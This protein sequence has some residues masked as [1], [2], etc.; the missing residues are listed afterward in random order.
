MVPSS[1]GDEESKLEVVKRTV[2]RVPAVCFNEQKFLDKEDYQVLVQPQS[3]AVRGQEALAR[4][5]FVLERAL[6]LRGMGATIISDYKFKENYLKRA[7]Q[8]VLSVLN[9]PEDE[10][11]HNILMIGPQIGIVCI[12]V[13]C[14][15][16]STNSS[17]VKKQVRDTLRQL[18]K[19]EKVLKHVLE[20]M[21]LDADCIH[22]VMALPNVTTDQ[23]KRKLEMKYLKVLIFLV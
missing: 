22:L 17:T 12:Q 15:E 2:M 23:L 6:H 1:D 10:G 21:D 7:P 16:E 11:S 18:K 9:R 3:P 19:D 13:T 14:V 4:V 8:D 5:C 20:D